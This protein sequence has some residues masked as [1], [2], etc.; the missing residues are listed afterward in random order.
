MKQ[1]KTAILITGDESRNKTMCIP[2]GG[3]TTIKI[4]LPKNWNKLMQ[5]KGYEPLEKFYLKSDLKPENPSAVM[6]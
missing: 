4:E 6:S 1:G 3:M 2:G 5:E